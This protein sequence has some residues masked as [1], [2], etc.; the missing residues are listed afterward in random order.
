MKKFLALGL[1]A[2]FFLAPSVQAQDWH[3]VRGKGYYY[4]QHQPVQGYHNYDRA[5][6]LQQMKWRNRYYW[7][8]YGMNQSGWQ[9]WQST[10][11][12]NDYH[13]R[14]YDNRQMHRNEIYSQPIRRGFYYPSGR[15]FKDPCSR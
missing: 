5:R 1:L 6:E 7:G 2:V 13:Q 3:G 11:G 9:Q 14:W 8:S 4:R 12:R 15:H 10:W